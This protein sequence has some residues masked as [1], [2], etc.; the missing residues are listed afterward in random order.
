MESICYLWGPTPLNIDDSQPVNPYKWPA[1]IFTFRPASGVLVLLYRGDNGYRMRICIDEF[2]PIDFMPFKFKK[3]ASATSC[4]LIPG[5][6]PMNYT[7]SVSRPGDLPDQIPLTVATPGGVE[8]SSPS[9]NIQPKK[10]HP[11][12]HT[13]STSGGHH[14]HTTANPSTT[15]T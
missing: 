9:A 3:L 11:R 10:K 4:F 7:L 15:T 5:S 13:G 8:T 1:E 6:T 2:G 14:G 12:K